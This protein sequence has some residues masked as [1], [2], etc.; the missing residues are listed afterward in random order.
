MTMADMGHIVVSV[1]VLPAIFIVKILHLAAH[2]LNRV[3]V[4]EFYAFANQSLTGQQR[5][6]GTAGIPSALQDF[7]KTSR[8]LMKTDRGKPGQTACYRPLA[9]FQVLI[10][11]LLLMLIGGK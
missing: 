5:F 11:G 4:G 8:G 9:D 2:D 7:T 3:G 6:A 1:Q 10:V